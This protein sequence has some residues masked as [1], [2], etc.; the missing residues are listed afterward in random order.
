MKT[1]SVITASDATLHL[2]GAILLYQSSGVYRHVY[3]TRNDIDV[4]AANPMRRIIGAGTPLQH[5]DLVEFAAA[6][7]LA[8]TPGGFVP[9]NLLYTSPEMIAWWVP[10]AIRTTW[11]KTA[12]DEIGTTHGL[13]A[14]PALLF[15]ATRAGWYVF[16]L[17]E[18]TRPYTGTRLYHAPHFNIYD[19]G[20]I[21]TGNVALPETLDHGALHGYEEAFFRSHFTH[22]NRRST[23]ATRCKG[24][25]AGLWSSQLATPDIDAMTRALSPAKATFLNKIEQIRQTIHRN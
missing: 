23:R 7:S 16:A 14:H 18:S 22:S 15:I 13:A 5:S 6:A 3:A 12:F 25:A 20:K 2:T 17:K 19:D 4:D 24:G 21:C 1:V 11:F 9:D 10:A 8:T